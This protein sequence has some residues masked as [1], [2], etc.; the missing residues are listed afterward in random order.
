MP[1]PRPNAVSERLRSAIRAAGGNQAVA[2]RARVPLASLNNYLAGREMRVEAAKRLAHAC[3][4]TVEWLISGDRSAPLAPQT[5]SGTIADRLRLV[6]HEVGWDVA[7]LS[8]AVGLTTEQ[9][10]AFLDGSTKP[11]MKEAGLLARACA[12]TTVWLVTGQHRMWRGEAIRGD[13]AS[14]PEVAAA[15]FPDK[16]IAALPAFADL[17][18]RLVA[19]AVQDARG[20]ALPGQSPAAPAA[21]LHLLAG[22]DAAPPAARDALAGWLRD[23]AARRTPPE[24]EARP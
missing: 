12:V 24:S 19:L 1:R 10:A 17:L 11:T 18:Q 4:V 15:D 20:L 7:E 16:S 8:E 22:W 5:S 3:G 23:L 13:E 14:N 21:L 2:T 9:L 6:M